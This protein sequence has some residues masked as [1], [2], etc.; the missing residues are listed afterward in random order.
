VSLPSG[1]I[2]ASYASSAS[3]GNFDIVAVNPHSGA[4]QTL[5]A[6]PAG[7][8]LVDAVLVYK[9]PPR[10]LYDNRRQLVFG[11]S[12]TGDPAH[13]VLHMP[14]APMVFTLLTGNLRRGRPVDAF[15]NAK[16]LAIYTEGLCPAGACSANTNGIYQNRSLLGR[17][18]LADD[19]S[20]RV[21][22]PSATGVV[23]ELQDDKQNTVVKMG[24]EHQLGPGEQISMGIVQPLFDAVCA[25][26]HGSVTGHEVDIRVT[27]DALTGASASLSAS[28][29]PATIP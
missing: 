19:G 26:C 18:Q 20:V 11:G 15:R 21:Q 3:T 23:L 9:Y 4:Q 22:L 12:D 10:A 6:A 27:P 2:M 16:F 17:A 5:I 28:K 14:D 7:S 13:A 1:E 8:A 29:P 25:G 24:E